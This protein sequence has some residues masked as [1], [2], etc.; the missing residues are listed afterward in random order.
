VG[1]AAP[2]PTAPTTPQS[3]LGDPPRYREEQPPDFSAWYSPSPNPSSGSPGPVPGPAHRAQPGPAPWSDGGHQPQPG[4]APWAGA[5]PRRRRSG[6]WWKIALVVLAMIG[7]GAGA[8]VA[9]LL[10]HHHHS[11]GQG[12]QPP[13]TGA[14][15]PPTGLIYAI[16]QQLAASPPPAGYRLY[17]QALASGEVAGFRMDIPSN[18]TVTG[19]VTP[20]G[21]QT[22]IAGP[23][24]D[25]VHM[26]VDL[27]PHTFKDMV[28]E[29]L[30]IE[31][32]SHFTGYQRLRIAPLTIRGTPGA[33]W[34]FTWVRDG[35]PQ[36]ALDLLFIANTPTGPQSYAL[37]ATAPSSMWNQLQATFDEQVRTFA[38]LLPAASG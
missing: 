1:L 36:T 18:W 37:Y 6:L 38:P 11:G 13:A 27:T 10:N 17:S 24:P 29:A 32:H 26:L 2:E 12:G 22:Y 9:T 15:L 8:A 20:G 21:T 16:N 5:A 7:A 4:T 34:K 25:D 35:V 19:K 33:W 30:Y 3:S 14:T 28:A 23:G 31:R